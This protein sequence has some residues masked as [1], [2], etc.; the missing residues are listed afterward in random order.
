MNIHP[1]ISVI[2]LESAPKGSDPYNRP[3]NDYPALIEE[4]PWNSIEK[5][6]GNSRSRNLRIA[7]RDG[8]AEI[9]RLLNI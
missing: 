7:V 4:D 5:N 3:R 1:V 8:T 9:R 6:G 2:H